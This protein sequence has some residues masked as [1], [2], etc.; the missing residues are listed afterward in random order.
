MALKKEHKNEKG[1]G[2][3]PVFFTA[4]ATIL[5]AILF[6]RFGFAVGTLGFWGV[7]LVIVL[8][9][10]V[11][12]PTALAISELATNKRVEGG[13][14]YFIISRSFGLNIGATIGFALFLS[15]AI[16]MAFYVIAFTESFD[17][18]FNW[19]HSN[20]D[21]NLPRQVISVP[22]M[23]LLSLLIIFRGANL[24]VKTLYIVVGLLGISLVLFFAGQTGYASETDFSVGEEP[25][26]NMDQF[27]FVFAIVFPA[28]TGMTA[29]VGLSGDLRKP[30]RSIPMGTIGAAIIGMVIYVFVIYKLAS[31][32]SPDDLV[33]NQLVMGQI[34]IGGAII[35]PLGLAAST[36][37]SA[38]GSAM[39]A[40]RTLQALAGDKSI[41]VKKVN[42]FL[43]L[44]RKKDGEPQNASIIACAIAMI[45]VLVGNINSV[46][47]VIS[48][49][50][51]VTYGSLNLISFLNHFG[52]PPSYRPSFKSKWYL[53]LLGFLISIWVMFKI[54]TPYA[55]SAY[56]IMIVIY[57]LINYYHKSRKG[58]EAIFTNS[59]FQMSR[60]LQ[61]Y[62]QKNRKSRTNNEW[63]PSAICISEDSFKRQ[64][65]FN[66]LNW[67]SYK[68]GFGT[69]I[70]LINGYYSRKAYLQSKHELL[71]LLRLFNR[72]NN[73]V[74]I[75]TIVSPSYSAS[76]VN[77]IQ[78]PGI[79]GMENN[80][81]IFEFDRENPTNLPAIIDNFALVNSGEFDM[82]IVGSSPKAINLHGDI[83]LWIHSDFEKN[84]NLM[85]LLGFIILGHSDWKKSNIKIFEICKPDRL[86]ENKEKM[87]A[88]IQTGRLPIT[89]KNIEIIMDRPKVSKK[90]LINKKSADAGLTLIGFSK[91]ALKHKETELFSGYDEL[92]TVIFVHA[93][94]PMEIE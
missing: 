86:E 5:G 22:L 83:H 6:L 73:H 3:A 49:F 82:C 1:F 40:P 79:A 19:V 25:L 85:I 77:A 88:L 29:G 11:T 48:M 70:H 69:Y 26:R 51:L 24:G 54:N 41:P 44:G 58:M 56:A 7:I 76:I 84:A 68:Y 78:V 74:Y 8:G 92:G 31:S 47:V 91:D 4:I 57:L 32:A 27:F 38:I 60:N 20:F 35:I 15:Q 36:L 67:I 71:R 53:S 75:D 52:S 89:N 80:M 21:L 12:I 37:S 66:F 72:V 17:F 13:G 23:L 64:T 14:E 94:G 81:V 87:Q 34:A 43:A 18:F 16:S 55:L 63:R 39:I 50:F 93:H 46:A 33:N 30:S 10:L 28:F 42:R 65:A 45:F 61:V 90:E 62:L 9:H 59:I 2:V